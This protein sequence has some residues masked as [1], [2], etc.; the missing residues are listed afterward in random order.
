MT[1]EHLKEMLKEEWIPGDD[2]PRGKAHLVEGFDIQNCDDM[3]CI[4]C[5]ALICPYGEPLHF[6]HDG[7]PICSYD[8]QG[9]LL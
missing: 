2:L 3:E 8:E 7:C 6:H 1:N 5:S 9:N 4:F